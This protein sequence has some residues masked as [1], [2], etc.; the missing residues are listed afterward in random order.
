MSEQRQKRREGVVVSDKMNK[1]VVVE[2]E[3]RIRHPRYH[4]FLRTRH[5][6][7]AHDE[8]NRCRIGDRVRLVETRP[9]SATKRWAVQAII[10]RPEG[11]GENVEVAE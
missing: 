2:V 5:R 10:N 4:K 8:T 3:R 11:S 1:T 9:L 6:Y 7:H